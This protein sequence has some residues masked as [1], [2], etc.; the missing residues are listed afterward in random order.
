MGKK[1][2]IRKQ[3]QS[4]PHEIAIPIFTVLLAVL[5]FIALFAPL[6]E[7]PPPPPPPPSKI[8]GLLKRFAF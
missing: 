8:L 6:P 7:P 2:P 3:A 4:Q 1:I 5:I